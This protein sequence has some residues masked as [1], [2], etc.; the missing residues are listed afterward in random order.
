MKLES[1]G[2]NLTEPGIVS[3]DLAFSQGTYQKV[4]NF[5]QKIEKN[6]RVMDITELN[7]QNVGNNLSL[8]IKTYYLE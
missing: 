2:F 7:F 6:I 5:I 3:I 8:K 4:K 1:F